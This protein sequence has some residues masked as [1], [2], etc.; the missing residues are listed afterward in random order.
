[1]LSLPDLLK[2]SDAWPGYQQRSYIISDLGHRLL[3][4][5]LNEPYFIIRGQYVGQDM[6]L[7]NVT[8]LSLSFIW[9]PNTKRNA[10]CENFSQLWRDQYLL[11]FFSA[12]FLCLTFKE[13]IWKGESGWWLL[14]CRRLC[15][16]VKIVMQEELEGAWMCQASGCGNMGVQ[17]GW[18][19]RENWA[20][21][22][23]EHKCRGEGRVG[24]LREGEGLTQWFDESQERKVRV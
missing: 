6:A 10:I 1:M 22:G 19:G 23:R 9:L 20:F 15:V 3:R 13:K 18:R 5:P 16:C 21:Q 24:V 2:K 17:R 8:R 12:V 11:Y 7:R 14:N 4:I